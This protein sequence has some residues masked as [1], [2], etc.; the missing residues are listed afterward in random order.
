MI[1]DD[2]DPVYRIAYDVSR[3]KAG[4]VLL[5]AALGG[6]VPPAL[7]NDYFSNSDGW[8]LDL[9]DCKVYSIRRSQ[10]PQLAA[11]TNFDHGH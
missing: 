9:N 8:T 7:F 11:R 4:C 10:L 1:D 6:T 5:Q 2:N 3:C